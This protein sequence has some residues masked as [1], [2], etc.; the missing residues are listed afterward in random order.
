[1]SR[2]PLFVFG[3][4]VGLLAGVIAGGAAIATGDRD[5][6]DGRGSYKARADL[7]GPP[8]SGIRGKALFV[9]RGTR[10]QPEP[11]VKV[12][13]TVRG[14]PPGPRERG[15]H[16]HQTGACEPPTFTAAGGHHDYGEPPNTT[17]DRNHPY[18][19]G[20]LPNLRV[21]RSGVGHM[22]TTTNR[23]VLQPNHP[24]SIFDADGAVVI[25]HAK[26]DDGDLGAPGAPVNGPGYAGGPRHACGVIRPERPRDED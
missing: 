7:F 6:D 11:P 9:Q 19:L 25:V 3:L 4:C 2:S 20:D 23:I 12:V 17:P 16:I 5:D 21:S 14:L 1:M 26:R 10:D 13:V 15:F 18:H 22:T 8:G 24:L